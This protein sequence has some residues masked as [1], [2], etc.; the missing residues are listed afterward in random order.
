MKSLDGMFAYVV[1]D[2]KKKLI[3]LNS[4]VQGEKKIF[5][6]EDDECLICSSSIK[7]ILKYIRKKKVVLNDKVIRDYFDMINFLNFNN[8]IYKK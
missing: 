5:F 3:Y 7:S 1:Y 8:S 4:D 6:Y 2:Q